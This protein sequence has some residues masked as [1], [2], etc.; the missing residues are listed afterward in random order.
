MHEHRIHNRLIATQYAHNPLRR[1]AIEPTLRVHD[2]LMIDDPDESI[3]SIFSL[4]QI[5]QLLIL[6]SGLV[7]DA[8]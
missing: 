7:Q 8:Q 4:D 2:K 5:S 6:L 1:H 3:I